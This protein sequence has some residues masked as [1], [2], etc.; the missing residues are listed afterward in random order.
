MKKKVK[1]HKLGVRIPTAKASIPHKSKKDY[2]RKDNKV[3]VFCLCDGVV[4]CVHEKKDFIICAHCKKWKR[5]HRD[6]YC[7]DCNPY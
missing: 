6:G 1:D 4:P 3:K 7:I 5:H 2:N